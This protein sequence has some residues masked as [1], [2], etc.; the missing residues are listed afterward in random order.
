MSALQGDRLSS[1]LKRLFEDSLELG[2]SKFINWN[3]Y[4]EQTDTLDEFFHT[5]FSKN[6]STYHEISK[7][8]FKDY[9]LKSSSHFAEEL[10]KTKLKDTLVGKK[11]CSEIQ[12]MFEIKKTFI[13]TE[14][15][16]TPAQ[17]RNNSND[18]PKKTK[19]SMS[20]SQNNDI[21]LLKKQLESKLNSGKTNNTTTNGDEDDEID[22]SPRG[23]LLRMS[24]FSH[25]RLASKSSFITYSQVES[26][27]T[28]EKEPVEQEQH[29]EELTDDNKK[30]STKVNKE[31]VFSLSLPDPKVLGS[32]DYIEDNV[33]EQML[34]DIASKTN[35]LVELSCKTNDVDVKQIKTQVKLKN[36]LFRVEEEK[37][38]DNIIYQS[39]SNKTIVYMTINLLLKKIVL[40][41]FLE[42]NPLLIKGFIQQCSAFISLDNLIHKIISAFNYFSYSDPQNAHNLI[43]FM[44]EL[45][46]HE[47]PINVSSFR[48]FSVLLG[49][50]LVLVYKQVE[51][52]L[53]FA[54]NGCIVPGHITTII[55]QTDVSGL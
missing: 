9:I 55:S 44:N 25:V 21:N 37:E 51:F 33:D 32:I 29:E 22:F 50:L 54:D 5:Q 26:T 42:N 41:N 28:E 2:C 45:I 7:N 3:F 30:C 24:T 16:Q 34:P 11:Y 18:F 52:A 46:Q 38:G 12:K 23:Q 47:S 36:D 1:K 4:K 6:T 20:L 49:L 40:E 15:E 39:S 19:F 10:W 13:K 17:L 35:F 48:E 53:K 14:T 27:P 43:T 8:L 31:K